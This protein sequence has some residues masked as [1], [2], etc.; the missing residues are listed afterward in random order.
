MG[1]LEFSF[2]GPWCI[3]GSADG[4]LYN[5]EYCHHPNWQMKKHAAD[6]TPY[7]AELIPFEQ[8]N[9][10][11]TQYSQLHKATDPHPFKEA[12]ISSFLPLQPYKVIAKFLNI[13][14]HTD[15]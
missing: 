7:P 8:I 4:G 15:F 9:S 1:K 2:N 13:G 3:L 6:I 5:I 10:P 12:G 14:N 11:N